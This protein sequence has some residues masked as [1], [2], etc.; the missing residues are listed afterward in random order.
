M[1]TFRRSQYRWSLNL[2]LLLSLVGPPAS[3]E[4]AIEF[5]T[6]SSSIAGTGISIPNPNGG[7]DII[8]TPTAEL[9]SG[10][11]V[12]EFQSDS[13]GNVLPGSA[14]IYDL[15]FTG[16]IDINLAT[17]IDV[18]GFPVAVSGTLTGPLSVM[19]TTATTGTLNAGSMFD[20]SSVGQYDI[21]IGPLNCTDSAFGVLCA[22]I[23]AGLQIDFP[24][25]AVALPGAPVPFTGGTFSQLNPGPA[26][27]TNGFSFNIPVGDQPFGFDASLEWVETGRLLVPE[28]SPNLLFVFGFGATMLLRRRRDTRLRTRSPVHYGQ[29]LNS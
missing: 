9:N 25:D 11:F 18:F 7:A 22:A 17:S 1:T 3:G 23:S 12:A 20:E 6:S 13:L 29:P 16:D 19:Q 8:I 15:A 28:P 2:V 5:Q 10:S 27:A 4:V 26:T 21:N 24:I 14:S